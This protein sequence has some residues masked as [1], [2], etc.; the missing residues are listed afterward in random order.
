MLPGSNQ[1]DRRTVSS[2]FY[3]HEIEEELRKRELLA[4][5]FTGKKDENLDAVM[6]HVDVLRC[7]ELYSHTEEDCSD[8]CK[9]RG[10]TMI[11]LK[12]I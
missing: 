7:G 4:W 8:D 10:N 3:W 5:T 2:A 11:L 1:L 6:K 9:K 12:N